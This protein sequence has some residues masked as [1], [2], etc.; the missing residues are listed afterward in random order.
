MRGAGCGA[1]GADSQKFVVWFCGIRQMADDE[2]LQIVNALQ[3]TK[4]IPKM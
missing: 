3:N 1:E 2:R 4:S